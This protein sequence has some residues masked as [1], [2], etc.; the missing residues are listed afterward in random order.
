MSYCNDQRGKA[1]EMTDLTAELFCLRILSQAQLPQAE[2]PNCVL[3]RFQ[4]GCKFQA[5]V[6]ATKT[7]NM[8]LKTYSN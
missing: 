7:Q 8:P 6:N 5:T 4:S 3:W 1:K 2:H